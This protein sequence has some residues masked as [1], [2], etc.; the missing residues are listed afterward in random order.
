MEAGW[1]S[2]CTRSARIQGV[3]LADDC[4]KEGTCRIRRPAKLEDVVVVIFAGEGT[5]AFA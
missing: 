5:A 1:P 3:L 4:P 2:R